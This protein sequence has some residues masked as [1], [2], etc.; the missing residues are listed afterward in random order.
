MITLIEDDFAEPVVPPKSVLTYDQVLRA[1]GYTEKKPGQY[2]HTDGHH[3]LIK[4]QP[5]GTPYTWHFTGTSS[6]SN[7][8]GFTYATLK[9]HLKSIHGKD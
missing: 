9:R 3:V 1:Y 6:V 5:K 2:T 4:A 8:S 7:N